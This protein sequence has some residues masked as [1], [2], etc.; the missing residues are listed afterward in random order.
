[1]RIPIALQA[2]MADGSTLCVQCGLCCDGTLFEVASL[3][4]GEEVPARSLGMKI[5]EHTGDV[6]ESAK[7]FALPCH[8]LKD[9]RCSVY[10][11]WRPRVCH[12]YTCRLLDGYVD[13]SRSVDECLR[14]IGI[15]RD[16]A[17]ELRALTNTASSEQST[18]ERLM[19]HAAL[20]VLR[21]KYF[22]SPDPDDVRV[23]PT[24]GSLD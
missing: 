6:G 8:L 3:A 23:P 19:A 20:E 15:V 21:R 12:R 22:K 10:E 16:V 7:G 1:V 4:D 24:L 14:V 13:G 18:G 2:E 9:R 17:N 11:D 5:I